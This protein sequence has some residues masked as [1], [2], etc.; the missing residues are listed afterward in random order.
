LTCTGPPP[1][2]TGLD[3]RKPSLGDSSSAPG[4]TFAGSCVG[5]VGG[6]FDSD[7]SW[8]I[9]KKTPGKVVAVVFARRE[10]EPLGRNRHT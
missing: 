4:V 7:L 9:S 3:G 5:R 10:A 6:A 1:P 2:P 8:E